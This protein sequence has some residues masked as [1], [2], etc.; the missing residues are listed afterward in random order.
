[1]R[2]AKSSPLNWGNLRHRA[3]ERL[4]ERKQAANLP[5]RDPERAVHELEVHQIEL[6]IQNEELR[7]S[8]IEL[9]TA[10]TRYTEI[11][12]FAPI[13]YVAVTLD[14]TIREINHAAARL[15][16]AARSHFP[17][18]NF[19]KLVAVRSRTQV[20]E[21]L[22]SV[23]VNDERESCEADLLRHGGKLYRVQLMATLLARAEPLLL[24][25]LQEPAAASL[26]PSSTEP[27]IQHPD[28]P[29]ARRN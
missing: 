22:R 8:R 24:L 9:E 15:L 25:A 29:E 27:S 13:G 7:E 2:T 14:G 1:M 28:A 12:D 16:G 17:G 19:S 26:A 10:L 4:R 5:A 3:E 18:E 23:M 11:F 6:E 20:S 21:M